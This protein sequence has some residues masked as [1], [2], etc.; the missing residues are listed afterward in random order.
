MKT[1]DTQI[2]SSFN[3][4]SVVE[5]Q[6]KYIVKHA[7]QGPQGEQGQQGPQGEQGIQGPQ[8]PQGEQGIQGPQGEQGIQGPQGPQ[9]P[10]GKQGSQGL[11]APY[12]DVLNGT[13]RA[14]TANFVC[15]KVTPNTWRCI[16]NESL[17]APSGVS[18]FIVAWEATPTCIIKKNR[19]AFC[20]FYFDIIIPTYYIGALSVDGVDFQIDLYDTHGD[21]IKSVASPMSPITDTYFFTN[22]G[23]YIYRVNDSFDIQAGAI[24]TDDV[25]ISK[26][27]VKFILKFKN[28]AQGDAQYSVYNCIP[29]LMFRV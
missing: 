13:L 4:S 5:E 17:Y 16:T 27:A 7:I 20:D 22:N 11:N 10:Q 14:T 3:L 23:M 26:I 18:G 12:I 19:Y 21:L 25:V 9:G 29:R 24:S 6:N 1:V 2:A 28:I 15:D 8:G